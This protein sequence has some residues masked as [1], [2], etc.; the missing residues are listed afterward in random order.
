M[1][2]VWP[3][4]SLQGHPDDRGEPGHRRDGRLASADGGGRHRP[5]IRA[6]RL[7]LCW[8]ATTAKPAG[9]D[10]FAPV[11]GLLALTVCLRPKADTTATAGGRRPRRRWRTRPWSSAIPLSSGPT[12][13][14][15]QTWRPCCA[16]CAVSPPI[17]KRL[18]CPRPRKAHGIPATHPPRRHDTAVPGPA[19]RPSSTPDPATATRRVSAA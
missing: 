8:L 5:P 19:R 11:L 18:R 7:R 3:A 4:A 1:H 15:Q 10:H 16:A 9:G 13:S 2:P 12:A 14:P 17:L 6:V